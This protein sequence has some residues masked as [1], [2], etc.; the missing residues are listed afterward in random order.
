MKLIPTGVTRSVG[1]HIL[2]IKKNSPRTMFVGGI[3]GIG[4]ST[5]LACRATLKLEQT[6]DN[7]KEEVDELKNDKGVDR[8]EL[9]YV[10]GKNSGRLLRLYGPSLLLGGASVA[11]LTGSHVTL[12]RRNAALTAAYSAL[13]VTFDQYIQRVKAELGE[14]RELDIRRGIVKQDVMIDGKK[15][16][17]DVKDPNG[18]SV[19]SKCFDESNP[20]W[21][22]NAEI[23]RVFL[24]CQQ[25][26]LNH[27]LHAR[28]HVFLNEVYE[29]LG[30]EHT[31][32]GSVVGW[33][34]GNGDNFVDFSIFEAVN[35]DFINGYER[36]IWL[37]FNVDGIIFDKI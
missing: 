20:E 11:L 1:R 27:R 10:Y 13:Q 35:A 33:V 6:L 36:S 34:V 32:A 28:G 19:Y 25:N 12:S 37:D 16:S 23:N 21:N 26:Y 4:V 29:A 3:I 9:A 17:I 18:R 31:Q 2:T 30:F 5:V 8:K 7:F 15:A 22:K 14:E 24:Q